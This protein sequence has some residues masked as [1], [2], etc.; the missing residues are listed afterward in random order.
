M[1]ATEDND[2]DSGFF[3]EAQHDLVAQPHA[4][5]GPVAEAEQRAAEISSEEQPLGSLGRRFDRRSPF[6][7]GV[8]ASAGVAVTYGAVQVVTTVSSILVLLGVAFFLALGLEPAVSWFVNRRLPRW[9]ATT[10]VFVIFL[11]LLGGFVAGSSSA[12]LG[13]GEPTHHR[14]SALHPA[15]PGPF[16]GDRPPQRSLPSAAADHRRD[17]PVTEDRS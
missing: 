16:V 14:S 10:L 3:E 2:S 5:E 7:V 15:G 13:A 17:E 6:F 8:E 4:D 9:A 11:A 1:V 12:A